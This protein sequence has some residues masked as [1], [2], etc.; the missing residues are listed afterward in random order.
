VRSDA[1]LLERILLNLVSNAVR[2]TAHGGVLVGCRR[3]GGMLRV[4]V[5]DTGPGIPQDQHKNIFGEFYQ[6]ARPA[7]DR[8]GGLGLGL[9]IVD[10]LCGLLDH[11]I[12]L[13]SSA[14]KGS[15]FA[16]VVPMVTAQAKAAAPTPAV[17]TDV[18]RGKLVVVIDDD[19]LVRDGMR[20]LLAGW[21]CA[22]VTAE[23]DSAALAELAAQKPDLIISDYRLA[24]RETGIQAIERLRAAFRA[25]IPAFLIS[26]DTTPERLRE[27][28]AG[29]YH[30]LHKPVPP[31]TLRAMI[32]QLLRNEA[33]TPTAAVG[34][35][36]L[37]F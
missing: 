34:A 10:R 30:L 15:R 37:R 23:S 31:M 3:R 22:V 11:P 33:R 25:P 26:G 9:A 27:A 5:W 20:G 35:S 6:L 17:T 32:S 4:E 29:G 2:Y 7:G 28:R 16:V 14:G 12:E 13:T 18:A 19:S 8:H 24:G 36:V 1:I 21:G